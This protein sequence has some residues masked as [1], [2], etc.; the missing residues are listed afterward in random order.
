[1]VDTTV[2]TIKLGGQEF[3]LPM[4]PPRANRIVY[5]LCVKLDPLVKRTIAAA[6]SFSP[7]KEEYSDVLDCLSAALSFADPPLAPGDFE[8][9][10][11]KPQ[12]HF[13]A[14]LHRSPA[15]RRLGDEARG[16]RYHAGGSDG[17]GVKDL[18]PIGM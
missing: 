10:V 17:E 8:N 6:F 14:L 13:D 11:E 16:G 3:K 7:S 12:A 5:P 4:L 15:D 18:T 2:R 1:M 9:L